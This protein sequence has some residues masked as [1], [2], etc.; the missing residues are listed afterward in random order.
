MSCVA[1]LDVALDELTR[2]PLGSL[3]NARRPTP[4]PATL[5][6]TSPL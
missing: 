5:G 3:R 4:E 1:D 6:C 2:A